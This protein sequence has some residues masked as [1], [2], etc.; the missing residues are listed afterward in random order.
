[1]PIWLQLCRIKPTRTTPGQAQLVAFDAA[2]HLRPFEDEQQAIPVQRAV[3]Y[4]FIVQLVRLYILDHGQ[5]PP[6][7]LLK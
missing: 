2:E 7:S 1:M 4:E 5:R 3:G 6:P